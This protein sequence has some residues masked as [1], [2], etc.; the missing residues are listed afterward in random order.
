MLALLVACASACAASAGAPATA[1]PSVAVHHHRRPKQRRQRQARRRRRERQRQATRRRAVAG[2]PDGP[3]WTLR[4]A[5]R[6]L[7]TLHVRR[8]GSLAGYSRTRFGPDWADVNH[9]GCDTRNDI[10]NRDLVRKTWEDASRCEVRTGVLHDPY[11]GRTIHFRRGVETSLAVQID[12]I[13]ALANAWE[14][15]ARR[16]SP[17]RRKAFANDPRELIAVYGPANEAK[18]D[19]NAAQWLPPRRAFDCQ[20]V[21]DQVMIKHAYGLS[22]TPAEDVAMADVLAGCRS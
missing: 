17:L 20:Y 16:W 19:D 21:T 15:G 12:H 13:V 8:S 5:A 7:P 1:H 18:R 10:L 11:T 3:H 6:V 4:Q 14:S 2:R 9:N 22:V